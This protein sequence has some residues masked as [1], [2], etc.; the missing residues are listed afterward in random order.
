MN[1]SARAGK[2]WPVTK[3]IYIFF[4]VF[5]AFGAV[6]QM[7]FAD[8]KPAGDEP[9]QSSLKAEINNQAQ[10]FG[11]EKGAGYGDVALMSDV[12]L[13]AAEIIK[14]FLT[15]LG[16]IYATYTVYGGYLWMTSAGNE[17]RISKSQNI[18]VHGVIGVVVIFSS[19]T[20]V[21][22]VQRTVWKA[23]EIPFVPYIKWGTLPKGSQK[24]EGPDPLQGHNDP[25]EQLVPTPK[26]YPKDPEQ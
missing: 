21:Y 25:L 16:I 14:I 5:F 10:A 3:K 8:T 7:G 23:Y 18:L 11:G 20:L 9:K 13:V 15:F 1:K 4:V 26:F 22:F 24:F 6:P 19:Y 12:R 17:E 2:Q